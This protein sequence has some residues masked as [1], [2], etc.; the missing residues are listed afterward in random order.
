MIFNV[1]MDIIYSQWITGFGVTLLMIQQGI[2]GGMVS[3][4]LAKLTA[5]DS[6]IF[7]DADEASWVASLINI[8]RLAGALIGSIATVYFGTKRS[9]FV[10]SIP[11]AIGWLCIAFANKVAILYVGRI[12][13]GIGVGMVFSTFP[14]YLGEV[15][16]PQIRGAVVSFAILGTPIGQ[17]L[18]SVASS[19]LT[20]MASSA[21]YLG[22]CIVL[23]IIF[24]FLPESP[25]Y[26]LK[27]GDRVSAEKSISWYRCG[28]GVQEE[29]DTV[30][31]LVSSE[32]SI[33]FID[34]LSELKKPEIR[35]AISQVIILFVFMQIT[36]VN[37]VMFYM[38]SILKKAKCT[39]VSPA[40][41]VIYINL[42]AA[43]ATTV[44]IFLIDKYGRKFLLL[45]SSSGITI[46]MIMMASHFFLIGNNVNVTNSQWLPITSML[47]YMI[48]F[49]IGLMPVPST[50]L[51]ETI[52]SNVKSIAA[53]ISSFTAG[54]TSFLSTKSYQ[55]LVILMG[56]S[57]IFLI[58]AVLAVFVIPYT[59][60]VML[61]TKGKTLQQIQDEFVRGKK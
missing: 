48:F 27:V 41:V 43:I 4:L 44:S 52:P 49:F 1:S 39:I 38:E 20:L 30:E 11:I 46:S 7:L 29:L 56:D 31:K 24:L 8:G 61:E 10:T 60:F 26:F 45:L 51:S 6:P 18:G 3:P 14:L 9:I 12:S 50:I 5:E 32:S 47:L 54:I 22:L 58:Y 55:P 57:Y 25:H 13:S 42:C 28:N 40:D 15:A 21:I 2:I 59:L 19:Y 23:A 35:K 37:S 36:G 34:R 16:M 17:M 53:C 33:K